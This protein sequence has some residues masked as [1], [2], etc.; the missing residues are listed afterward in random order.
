MWRSHGNRCFQ[1]IPSPLENPLVLQPS[2]STKKEKASST[3]PSVVLF[4]AL[5][6][7]S[8]LLQCLLTLFFSCWCEGLSYKI[9]V[10]ADSARISNSTLHNCNNPLY[11]IKVMLL[12]EMLQMGLFLSPNV[13]KLIR[14]HGCT[15]IIN[16]S[17][18]GFSNTYLTHYLSRAVP[19]LQG[20]FVSDKVWFKSMRQ[21]NREFNIFFLNYTGNKLK[22]DYII[23]IRYIINIF[24]ITLFWADVAKCYFL[25]FMFNNLK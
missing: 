2:T 17:V 10:W 5:S 20:I 8:V 18:D 16:K 12:Q 19:A 15:S 22:T 25:I 11:G 7:I 24:F 21:Q 23:L 6:Y 9:S 3:G 4:L 14:F 1:P 13:L